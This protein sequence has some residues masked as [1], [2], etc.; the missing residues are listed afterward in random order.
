MELEPTLCQRFE[1]LKNYI[2]TDLCGII[3]AYPEETEYVANEIDSL[4]SYIKNDLK[5]AGFN[6]LARSALVARVASD[7]EDVNTYAELAI[8]PAKNFSD[9][10]QPNGECV[11]H[12]E[13][14]ILSHNPIS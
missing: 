13:S 1:S 10:C 2:N 11:S 3:A 14:V 4:A 7:R 8:P 12:D 9:N 6:A 5:H